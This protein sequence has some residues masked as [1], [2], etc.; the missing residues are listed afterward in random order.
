[1]EE[2]QTSL[3]LHTLIYGVGT[4]VALIAF[5]LI[6]YVTN[7]YMNTTLGYVSFL[8]MMGG[9]VYGSLQ[10]RK[11]Q[12]KGFMTYGQAFSTNFL[13]GLFAVILSTIFFFFY[14]KYINT[15][16]IDEILAQVRAKMEAKAGTMSQEQMD[17]AMSWTEKFMTPVWMIVWGF[18]ANIFWATIFSLLIAILLRKKDP[19][20]PVILQ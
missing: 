10:Y 7:L 16:L 13:I 2:K 17:Q 15:G 20:A 11:V 6:M 1:M 3:G 12:L 5:T 18:L 14:I 19:D 8:I 4:G 9:M